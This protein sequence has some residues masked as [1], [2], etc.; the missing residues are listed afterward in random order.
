[1]LLSLLLFGCAPEPAP[2][3]VD[4]LLH[5]SWTMYEEAT[6]EQ[7]VEAVLNLPREGEGEP[8]RLAAE[9][10]EHVEWGDSD[11]TQA[12]G[13]YIANTF[14]CELERLQE[15]LAAQD[16]MAQY[17]GVYTRYERT[18][19]SDLADFEANGGFLSWEVELEGEYVNT[20][21][22]ERLHGGLRRVEGALVART[23]ITEPVDFEEGSDWWWPTD[24]Q[25]EVF[26]EDE[27]E[28]VHLYGIWREL[29]IGS[30]STEDD[31]LVNLT[32]NGMRDWDDETE[33][34]CASGAR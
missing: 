34:L 1:M 7:W 25:I 26:A 5:W 6:D 11:V 27:G 33:S 8:S 10:V 20:A 19:T 2:A 22:T 32:R 24:V 28:I 21:Y 12:R 4:G 9:E 14:E 16:Q 18:Y 15:I 23:W 3:D 30:L 29:D 31:G 17:E 13:M